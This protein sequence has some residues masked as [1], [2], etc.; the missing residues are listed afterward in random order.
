[1]FEKFRRSEALHLVNVEACILIFISVILDMSV[2]DWHDR[3]VRI[4]AKR[5]ILLV[6]YIRKVSAVPRSFACL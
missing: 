3:L 5:R 4:A 6:S 2:L 1:M